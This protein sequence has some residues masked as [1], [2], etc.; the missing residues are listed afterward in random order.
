MNNE[1][2]TP[3][4]QKA[5][6]L[7]DLGFISLDLQPEQFEVNGFKGTDYKYTLMKNGRKVLCP[8]KVQDWNPPTLGLTQQ[9]Q[10]EALK[11]TCNSHCAR[12]RIRAQEADEKGNVNTLIT[13][14]CGCVPEKYMVTLSVKAP[15]EKP[16]TGLRKA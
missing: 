8:Y 3:P 12:F 2:N 5:P 4:P 13:L 14:T 16:V 1:Q 7:H 10:D 15:E 11:P 6:A 9:I